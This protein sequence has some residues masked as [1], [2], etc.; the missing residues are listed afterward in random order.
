[1][2]SGRAR[3]LVNDQINHMFS[4]VGSRAK[5][6]PR[7]INRRAENELLVGEE[8]IPPLLALGAVIQENIRRPLESGKALF[9]VLEKSEDRG[10]TEPL[11][12]ELIDHWFQGVY[13]RY[14]LADH[15]GGE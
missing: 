13:R 5:D 11:T 3:S 2:V 12:A 1:L 7:Q 14:P 8:D 15:D 6:L 10:R 9:P 4:I